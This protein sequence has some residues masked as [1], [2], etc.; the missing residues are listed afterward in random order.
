[1]LIEKKFIDLQ[2]IDPSISNPFN[3]NN[4]K[5]KNENINNITNLFFHNF[6]CI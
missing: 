6:F 4:E 3:I 5:I 2:K 1:M